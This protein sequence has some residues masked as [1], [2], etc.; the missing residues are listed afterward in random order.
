MLYAPNLLSASFDQMTI[1]QQGTYGGATGLHGQGMFAPDYELNS[2]IL[3]E[4]L[5][6][7][8]E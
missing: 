6:G 7:T 5:Y 3:R 4:F 2:Q 8:H 1:P